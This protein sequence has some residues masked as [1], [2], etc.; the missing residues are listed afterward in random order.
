MKSSAS[1][2]LVQHASRL[3]YDISLGTSDTKLLLG[4]ERIIRGLLVMLEMQPYHIQVEVLKTIKNLSQLP[5]NFDALEKCGIVERLCQLLWR[6]NNRG[7]TELQTQILN[8]LFL[9]L[10]LNTSRQDMAVRHGLLAFL[11]KIKHYTNNVNKFAIPLL[12]ELIRNTTDFGHLWKNDILDV[13]I[14]LARDVC[15][16]YSALDGLIYW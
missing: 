8:S 11:G 9:I 14:T 10:R 4:K 2:D 6:G 13:L 1:N 7:T 12:C 16:K 5:A 3:L 15:W